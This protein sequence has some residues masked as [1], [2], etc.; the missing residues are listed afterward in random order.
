MLK[1]KDLNVGDNIVLIAIVKEAIP[2]KTKPPGN[3]PYLYLTVYDGADAISGNHWDYGDKNPPPK[4]AV[5]NVHAV[6]Q[7][8][9][10]AKQLNI[11]VITKNEEY[12]PEAFVPSGDVDIDY[13]YTKARSMA[14]GIIHEALRNL[15]TEV[16]T[17][18]EKEWR[19][20]PGA[21][22]VHHAYVGALLKHSVDVASKADAIAMLTPGAD[23]DLV[24]AGGLLHDFGKIWTYMYDGASIEFTQE[25]NMLEH[26]V[27][28]VKRTEKYRTPEN[29]DALDLIH[30]IMVSHHGKLEYGSPMTPKFLEAWIVNAADMIDAKAE[31]IMDANRKAKPGDIYTDKVWSLENRQMFTQEYVRGLLGYDELGENTSGDN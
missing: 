10:G 11:K 27:I 9:Q 17:E 16:F 31:T 21:K 19:T 18:F 15:V 24:M 13:Y 28:G 26:L 2:K 12:G 3:K 1:I 14:D 20:L 4:N 7:E 29:S 25:G 23:A 6:V 8:W 5:V 30:H 22:T